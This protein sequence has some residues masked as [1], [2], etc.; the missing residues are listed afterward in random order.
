LALKQIGQIIKQPKRHAE[1]RRRQ[2]Q[3]GKQMHR[4]LNVR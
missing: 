4:Q 1:E 3:I 2:R